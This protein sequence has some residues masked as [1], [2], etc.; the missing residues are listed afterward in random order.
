MCRT[1]VE[2]DPEVLKARQD[3]VA[4]KSVSEL[5]NIRGIDDFPL[6]TR[7]ETMVRKKRVL[8]STDEKE[9][10]RTA[11]IGRS[12]T[13]LSTKSLASLGTVPQSLKT[14][15]AVNAVVEDQDVVAKNKDIIKNKSVGE[16]SHIGGLADI[17]I[18]DNV[19]NLY[20]K[21]TSTTER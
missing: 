15:L 16:L 12:L 6:P 9:G 7:I 14:P 4:G 2:A 19:E 10:V 17:P 8:K 20:K 13:S 18:P 1:K 3:I 21:L 5:S 11:S